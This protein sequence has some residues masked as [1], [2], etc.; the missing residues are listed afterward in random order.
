MKTVKKLFIK[1]LVPRETN[2]ETA[3]GRKINSRLKYLWNNV[4][5]CRDKEKSNCSWP[6]LILYL[7]SDNYK[8]H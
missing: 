5:V 6:K 8:D 4:S 7:S 2:S 1:T 3:A